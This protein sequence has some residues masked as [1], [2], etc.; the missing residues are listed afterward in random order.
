MFQTFGFS[1]V[2]QTAG[3]AAL[4]PGLLA[5]FS[6]CEV[7]TEF[8]AILGHAG[9]CSFRALQRCAG[10][11]DAFRSFAVDDLKAKADLLAA[12]VQIGNLL[13]AWHTGPRIEIHQG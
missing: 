5:L 9:I 1:E 3:I 7:H 6:D 12:K 13:E 8:Q 11:E 4:E 2:P 10:T